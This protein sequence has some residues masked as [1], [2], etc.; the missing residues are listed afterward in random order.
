MQCQI[1][2]YSRSMFMSCLAM[3]CQISDFTVY[4][5]YFRLWLMKLDR[6]MEWM[7]E[8][9]SGK[10]LLLSNE[11]LLSCLSLK[12]QISGLEFFLM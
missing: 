4:Y 8:I 11:K 12:S 7:I 10:E 6:C 5:L 2:E 1:L 3:N 9:C